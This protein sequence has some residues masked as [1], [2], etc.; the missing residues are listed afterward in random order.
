MKIKSS[1]YFF[2]AIVFLIPAIAYAAINWYEWKYQRLPVLGEGKMVD[3][4]TEYHTISDFSLTNQDGRH[5]SAAD[6]KG[7]IVVANFF[8]T[9]CPAICPAMTKNL[10]KVQQAFSYENKL[11]FNSF[12]VDPERDSISQLKNFSHRF[13]IDSSNWHLL[14]GEKKQIYR[15]ARNSFMVVAT[16]GDGGPEDFIHSESLVLIDT[17]KR[18]RGYYK[19]TEDGDIMKLIR[20]IKKLKDEN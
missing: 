14:T 15:L 8:F 12:T 10:R 2:I 6:W 17:Q 5:I 19:G 20:D 11:L 16:D 1:V 4:K 7:K 9:H 13:N 18:I 3:G